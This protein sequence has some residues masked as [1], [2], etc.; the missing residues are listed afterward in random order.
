MAAAPTPAKLFEGLLTD[1]GEELCALLDGASVPG[2]LE[3]LDADRSLEV[4]CLFHGKLEPDMAE[5]A[6]YLVKLSL[7]SEFTE[8]L[9]GTG[10]G[11]H[12]GSFVTSRQ[13]FRRLRNHL[14]AL[15]LIYRRDGTPLYFRYYDPRVL[16]I[17][18][19][20]CS[21]AQ[22]K[23][24]FGPVDAFLAESEAGDAV[25]IYRLAGEELSSVQRKLGG[26]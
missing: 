18:L 12:W 8:W 17:F 11:H 22:L 14:R 23:Q 4:E 25:S 6:P 5:V 21:A 13:S 20:T 2:L 10:W 1:E 3:R 7:E 16:R 19:P 26:G 24:M 15:T 9:V